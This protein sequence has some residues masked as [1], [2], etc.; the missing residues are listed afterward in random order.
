MR[1]LASDSRIR[2]FAVLVIVALLVGAIIVQRRTIVDAIG[3]LRGFSGPTVAILA[4]LGIIERVS[5][6]DVIRSLLPGTSLGRAE[7]IGDVG[8]AVSKG[9]PAGGPLATLLR[10]QIARDSGTSAGPFVHMLVASGV[11]TAFVSWGYPLVATLA[12]ISQRDASLTDLLIIAAAAAVLIGSALFWSFALFSPKAHRWTTERAEW[13]RSKFAGS[14]PGLATGDAVA[15]V[16]EVRDS[17]RATARRPFALLLR[18]TIAQGTGIII[19]WTALRG[20]GVGDELGVTEFARVFFVAHILGSLAPTPGGVGVIEAG[21]TGALVAAGVQADVALAGVIVYR[22]ITYVLPILVGTGL[23]L[24]WRRT[25]T[26]PEP[27]AV[28]VEGF[29]AEPTG[30]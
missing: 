9:V 29:T 19:L 21:L 3:L 15:F 22:F 1:R 17:L 28:L 14:A 13:V 30:R 18:T 4:V 11:A 23:Y 27:T 25:R 2:R 8:S 12:D 16:D 5:R 10:W 7:V 6:A 24:W 26:P 20:L